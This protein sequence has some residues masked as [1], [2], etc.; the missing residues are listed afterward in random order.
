[1]IDVIF[2]LLIFFLT[3]S[4]FQLL[5]QSMPSSVS[6]LSE[7]AAGAAQLPA[8]PTDDALDEVI[9]KLLETDGRVVVELNQVALA[10]FAELRLRLQAI[11]AVR[12]DVPVIIDPEENVQAVNVIRAYD[13]A[14]Q[15][16]LA[17]VFLATRQST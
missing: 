16:G 2:L 9:V 15:A 3:T 7:Q 14:R 5:E 4:S 1:M 13:W 10:S 8:D 17:R 12:T 6:K 11:G